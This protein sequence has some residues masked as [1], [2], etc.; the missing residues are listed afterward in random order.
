MTADGVGV[1]AT[2]VSPRGA[3]QETRT[4]LTNTRRVHRWPAEAIPPAD[5]LSPGTVCG[6]PEEVD[7]PL[8]RDG[9]PESPLGE[10]HHACGEGPDQDQVPG[11]VIRQQLLQSEEDDRAHDGAFDSPQ[12]AD[13]DGEDPLTARIG[14]ME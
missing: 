9:S 5:R 7:G 6:G 14:S 8:T 12:T 1:A 10:Y 2:R 3:G 13:D 4:P 11:A